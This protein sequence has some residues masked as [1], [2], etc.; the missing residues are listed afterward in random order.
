MKTQN[1]TLEMQF[2][3]SKI[4]RQAWTELSRSSKV[5]WSEQLILKHLNK[6]D[7]SE[8]SSNENIHWTSSMLNKFMFHINWGKLTRNYVHQFEN[9]DINTVIAFVEKYSSEVDWNVISR[10]FY[11][12]RGE[13]L[14]EKFSNHIEWDELA[15]NCRF[16]WTQERVEKYDKYLSD[17]SEDALESVI[18]GLVKEKTRRLMGQIATDL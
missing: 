8:L 13:Q 2:M 17:L 6:W 11:H 10:W 18:K 7:W 15:Q 9:W 5:P 3:T 14:I 1:Q 4:K 16:T 12:P